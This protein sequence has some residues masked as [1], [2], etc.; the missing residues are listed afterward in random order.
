M[1]VLRSSNFA[2][3]LR[4]VKAA[5]NDRIDGMLEQTKACLDRI[6]EKLPGLAVEFLGRLKPVDRR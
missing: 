1:E 4:L 5:K 2:E 3:Y 6:L